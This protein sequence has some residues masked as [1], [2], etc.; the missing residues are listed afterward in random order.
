MKRLYDIQMPTLKEQFVPAMC[1]D[2]EPGRD[3][4]GLGV[5]SYGLVVLSAPITLDS[6]AVLRKAVTE[7]AY[8]LARELRYQT[9]IYGLDGRYFDVNA[10]SFLW[11]NI[12]TLPYTVVGACCFQRQAVE[13]GQRQSG[14]W[15]L[16][17]VWFHPYERRRGHLLGAWAYFADRFPGFRVKALESS[18][19]R[20]FLEKQGQLDRLIGQAEGG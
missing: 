11:V 1:E 20:A 9:P 5:T 10:R 8:Y 12:T 7:C 19:L 13:A 6:S 14:P 4:P 16:K 3:V 18:A 15:V 2:I 17:W